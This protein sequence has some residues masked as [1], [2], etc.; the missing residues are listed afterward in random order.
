[1]Y[2]QR[3]N[4]NAPRPNNGRRM[5]FNRPPV[6]ARVGLLMRRGA[7]FGALEEAEQAVR[8]AGLGLAPLSTGDEPLSEG[9]ITILATASL[10]DLDSGALRGLVAPDGAGDQAD[11]REA[12]KRALAAGL[13]VVA[14][15]DSIATVAEVAGVQP[16]R[17]PAALITAEGAKPL[18]DARQLTAAAEAIN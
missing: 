11:V 3:Q 2:A 8:A 1:M 10:A 13:P 17:T 5:G 18:E 4:R 12:A 14:F 16:A 6:R 15:G 7:H 9:G